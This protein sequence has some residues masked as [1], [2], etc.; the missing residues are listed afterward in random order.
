MTSKMLRVSAKHLCPVCGKP[1][2]CL[3]TADGAAAICARIESGKPLGKREPAGWLHIL[4]AQVGTSANSRQ[5]RTCRLNFNSNKALPVVGK[6]EVGIPSL[7]QEYVAALAPERL[8]VLASSLGLTPEALLQLEVGWSEEH[9]AYS[10][11]MRDAAGTVIGIR[12]RSAATGQKFA[13][14]GSRQGLFV[15]MRLGSGDFLITEGPTDCAA[16]LSLGF[17]SVGRPNCNGGLQLLTELVRVRHLSQVVVVADTDAPG[18]A[19]AE[20]LADVLV[21]YVPVRIVTPPAKDAREWVLLGGTRDAVQAAIA[22]APLRKLS[23]TVWLAGAR[24]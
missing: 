8:S 15:P 10:F 14:R 6:S 21:A 13:V 4:R 16:M 9:A 1:D 11:P 18:Q 12:L 7:A 23:M 17:D 5:T 19:G 2:W 3:R 20:R 22:A 24:P